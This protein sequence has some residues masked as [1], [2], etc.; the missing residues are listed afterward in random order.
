MTDE[1]GNQISSE[2]A[3]GGLRAGAS[4]LG[5]ALGTGNATSSGGVE[6]Y[7]KGRREASGDE[8]EPADTY[9]NRLQVAND[10]GLL[11]QA[12][13]LPGYMDTPGCREFMS[14]IELLKGE[15]KKKQGELKKLMELG[16]GQEKIREKENQVFKLNSAL[17]NYP[18]QNY[19]K[20]PFIFTL[21][22]QDTL[23]PVVP[24]LSE[25]VVTDVNEH[26][27][28][29]QLYVNAS[30]DNLI[31]SER[32]KTEP[33]QKLNK[34]KDP[35]AS[36]SGIKNEDV[37]KQILVKISEIEGSFKIQLP[38]SLRLNHEKETSSLN[39]I[40]SK[41]VVDILVRA[42]RQERILINS[43]PKE[44][45]NA[46]GESRCINNVA[47]ILINKNEVS[48]SK[49]L[50][51]IATF[52]HEAVHHYMRAD[53]CSGA[54]DEYFDEEILARQ[55]EIEFN[56]RLKGTLKLTI[57]DM[58][59]D[60]KMKKMEE[61]FKKNMHLDFFVEKLPDYVTGKTLLKK[62]N[63]SNT[64]EEFNRMTVYTLFFII[65]LLI[66]IE[67][68]KEI[69]TSANNP[70]IKAAYLELKAR[71]SKNSKTFDAMDKEMLKI[72]EEILTQ[73]KIVP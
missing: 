46:L 30:A 20:C 62:Y 6:N 7:I 14:D 9:S 71:A 49:Q 1:K 15:L 45:H 29:Q 59:Y 18:A 56:A 5:K 66:G 64:K 2:K 50:E 41:D 21:P 40:S 28:P 10:G 51:L 13:T 72:L 55:M 67:R 47:Y 69:Y 3:A 73:M 54:R 36:S 57:D 65:R 52:V 12:K 61:Y 58:A 48:D 25:R 23:P 68:P 4:A 33:A 17:K 26:D 22:E 19:W 24:A 32:K 42:Q 8:N 43:F 11:A 60:S 63:E 31:S 44:S 39:Y 35:G 70:L 53:I 34:I 37:I 16:A 38:T 27:M